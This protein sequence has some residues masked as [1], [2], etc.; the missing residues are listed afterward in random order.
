MPQIHAD[1]LRLL[2]H[3]L[4]VGAGCGRE[5]AAIVADH[6][7]EANLKGHDSHGIGNLP[8]Y[9]RRLGKGE[10]RANQTPRAVVDDGPLLVV[11]AGRGLGQSVTRTAMAMAMAI[12]RAKSLGACVMA[13]RNSD[14]MGRIGTYGEQ[15]AEAGLASLHFVN[16]SGGPPYV[17][18]SAAREPRFSTNP[19]CF[20]VPGGERNP[21]VILDC[22]TSQVAWG[23]LRV[24]HVRG[25]P[26]PGGTLIDR[27]GQPTTDI[28][29][30]IPELTGAMVGFGGYKGSGIALMCELLGAAI[31]GGDTIQP[32]NPR[33]GVVINNMLSI[34][35]DA[36]RMSDM[37]RL[38]S[39][40]DAM[41]D[42][43]LSATPIAP[44]EPVLVAGDPERRS[45]AERLASGIPIDP[46]TW[47]TLS[48]LAEVSGVAL[49][50]PA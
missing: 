50:T 31:G 28:G 22:A 25:Q 15:C 30:M 12:E 38:R 39:E 18:P 7:V 33:D 26:A 2:A 40:V 10:T 29:T 21:P 3:D 44:A 47:R 34:L 16:V 46:E 35:I 13:V 6:L 49:P 1:G 37:A 41:I 27:H 45:R 20:A 14:H 11:D 8:G 17:A 4:L 48:A 32:G 43:V 36:G 42:Y 24:A 23:K 9:L 19:F 5:E